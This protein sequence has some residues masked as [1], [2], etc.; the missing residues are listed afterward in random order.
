MV[1]LLMALLLFA[2]LI[3]AAQDAVKVARLELDVRQ[4]QREV[5]MLSQLVNQL[6]RRGDDAQPALSLP[7]PASPGTSARMTPAA[8][9]T[10]PQWVSASRWQGVRQGMTELE[11]IS[12]LGVPT[13]VRK[14]G[15]DQVLLYALELGS[16]TFLAGSVTLRNEGVLAV[17]VPVLK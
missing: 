13:S 1:R 8:P 10:L 16:A 6:R 3:A 5:S 15:E 4:L 2:P 7:P 14:Q 17:E 11:V 9:S 12:A